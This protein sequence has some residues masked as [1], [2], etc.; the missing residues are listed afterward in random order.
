MVLDR[1]PELVEEPLSRTRLPRG[2]GVKEEQG[3]KKRNSR[4]FQTSCVWW[5]PSRTRRLIK[6]HRGGGFI[7]PSCE[8]GADNG[9]H[10]DYWV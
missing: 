4:S 10:T 2:G 1:V 8:C 5:D 6:Q 3:L 7:S 9:V